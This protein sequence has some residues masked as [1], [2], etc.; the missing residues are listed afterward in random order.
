MGRDEMVHTQIGRLHE[1]FVRPELP[2]LCLWTHSLSFACWWK[3]EFGG[4]S[5][6]I[7]EMVTDKNKTMW[8]MVLRRE[9][10]WLGNQ[11][12]WT[13]LV[14]DKILEPDAVWGLKSEKNGE[15]VTKAFRK[16][17]KN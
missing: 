5:F 12:M 7:D 2:L 10:N 16:E 6:I 15:V 3:C 1:S 14:K 8:I 4:Y 17:L 11:E 9:D 13:Y